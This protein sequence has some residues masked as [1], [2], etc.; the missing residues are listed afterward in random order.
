M[1]KKELQIELTPEVA[2]GIYANLAVI[3]HSSSEFVADFI[4]ILPGMPKAQ[5]T[6]R[7][8]LTP[9]HAKR[10]LFALEEN[11]VK[12]EKQFG[13]INIGEG[14]PMSPFIVPGGEA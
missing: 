4:R 7:I 14:A 3:S 1:E 8:V 2:E 5:V 12:Y 11:V 9:E 13:K 6:S 10:L